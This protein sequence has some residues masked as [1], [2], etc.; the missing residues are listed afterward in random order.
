MTTIA[1]I[2]GFFMEGKYRILKVFQYGAKTADECA[3]FGFDGNPPNEM[4]AIFLETAAGGEP[5]IIGYIQTQ[6]LANQGE[7]RLYALNENNNLSTYLWLRKDQTVEIGGN[8]ENLV[9]FSKLQQELLN[10]QNKLNSEMTKIASGISTAGGVYI[11][12][13]ITI[14]I[15]SSKTDLIKIKGDPAV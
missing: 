9:K 2:K 13:A 7:A 3:P 4:D 11:P 8:N 6:R 14:N 5:V 10:L 12:D 1:K 15:Q